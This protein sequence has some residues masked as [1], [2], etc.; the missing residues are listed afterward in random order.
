MPINIFRVYLC[1]YAGKQYIFFKNAWTGINS[2]KLDWKLSGL[3]VCAH[4]RCSGFCSMMLRNLSPRKWETQKSS[5]S[6]I[7]KSI[8]LLDM[9]HI[10]L[11]NCS[12]PLFLYSW[13]LCCSNFQ[14]NIHLTF[15]GFRSLNRFYQN[16]IPFSSQFTRGQQEHAHLHWFL[17]TRKSFQKRYRYMDI[18]YVYIHTRQHQ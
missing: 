8:P 5:I 7:I 12:Y 4:F 2:I 6:S 14:S 13:E 17:S 1:V 3:T 9:N 16:S 15:Y 11:L 18:T 10:L